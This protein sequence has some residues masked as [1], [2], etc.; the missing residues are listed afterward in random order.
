MDDEMKYMIVKGWILDLIVE[1]TREEVGQ[2]LCPLG[3]KKRFTDK[4]FDKITTQVVNDIHL[5]LK[6]E[7][8]T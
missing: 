6:Y 1:A 4:E 5:K 2:H 3:F 7:K 8:P